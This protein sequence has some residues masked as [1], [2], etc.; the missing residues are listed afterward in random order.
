[1]KCKTIVLWWLVNGKKKNIHLKR[2]DCRPE[3]LPKIVSALFPGIAYYSEIGF[4]RAVEECAIPALR[5]RYPQLIDAPK[6]SIGPTSE[7]EVE[8]LM[9]TRAYEWQDDPRWRERLEG[10]FRNQT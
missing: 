6:R 1:M 10:M 7:T 4:N 8:A 9:L 5:K 2:G 3:T